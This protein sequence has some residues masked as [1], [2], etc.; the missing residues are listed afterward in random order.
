M[1]DP[2]Q[3]LAAVRA[4]ATARRDW[5]VLIDG[6]SG[7]G[8]TT[9]AGALAAATGA[10]LLHLDDLYPGWDG[11]AAAADSVRRQ[12]LVPRRTGRRGAWRRW[13]WRAG[14]PAERH[15]VPAGGGLVCEGSGLLTRRSAPL[16]DLTLWVELEDDERRRRALARDGAAYE[17]HWE[18][19]A[20]QERE[21]V[22]RER[23]QRLADLVVDGGRV[24]ALLRGRT[25]RTAYRRSP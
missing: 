13:D 1:A 24:Q 19:W 2:L 15:R 22:A 3:A 14:A 7:A 21:A 16:G 25:A 9:L 5:T 6:R 20:A 8:K 12:V 10:G 18:R 17:P 11:L 23:P 4:L